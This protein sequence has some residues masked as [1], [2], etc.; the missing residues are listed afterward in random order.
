MRQA[1][2]TRLER[3]EQRSTDGVGILAKGEGAWFAIVDGRSREF[4]T[5]HAAL[6][7]LE[8]LTETIIIDDV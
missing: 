7:F 2:L 1:L 4:P 8:R 6:A 3:L 5:E